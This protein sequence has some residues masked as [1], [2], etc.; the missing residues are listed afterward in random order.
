MIAAVKGARCYM[1]DDTSSAVTVTSTTA[2]PLTGHI[3]RAG[4]S[5]STLG[6]FWM[7]CVRM[8]RVLCL[9]S[10]RRSLSTY[11]K[12]SLWLSL[13]GIVGVVGAI[14]LTRNAIRQETIANLSTW[15]FDVDKT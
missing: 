3:Y 8:F 10:D 15:T 1:H 11:E 7:L 9:G 12:V 13:F 14:I 2:L 4:S 6:T 5:G